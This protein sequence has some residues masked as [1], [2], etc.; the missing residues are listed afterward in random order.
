MGCEVRGWEGAWLDSDRLF[1]E[2]EGRGGLV[3]VIRWQAW[4]VDFYSSFEA[5][6]RVLR[7]GALLLYTYRA[8][9]GVGRVASLLIC[10]AGEVS[11][12]VCYYTVSTFAK[13]SFKL[14][15]ISNKAKLKTDS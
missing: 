7:I 15:R 5:C 1:G 11:N 4:L 9:Q 10:S 6:R 12:L 2:R 14:R 8:A 13:V 3:E